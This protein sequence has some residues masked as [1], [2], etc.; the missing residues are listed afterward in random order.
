MSYDV[1]KNSLLKSIRLSPNRFFNFSDSLGIKL[2]TR[3]RLGLSHLR[4]HKFNH[5]FEETINPL[6]SCSFE[7]ES[8]NFFLRCQNFMDFRKRLMNEL[9]KIDSCILT[10]DKKSLTKL[11]LSGDGRYDSKTKV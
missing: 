8:T 6:S 3:L 4:E 7:S 1:F 11:L 5:N 9:V 10:L 2:L